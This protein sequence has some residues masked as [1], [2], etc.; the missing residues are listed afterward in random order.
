MP[1][2]V[3]LRQSTGLEISGTEEETVMQYP[4]ETVMQYPLETLDKHSG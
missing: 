2:P 3:Q 4:L 1:V